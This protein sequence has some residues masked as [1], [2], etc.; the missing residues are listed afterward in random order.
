M[1]PVS[2]KGG[3]KLRPKAKL[4]QGVPAKAIPL[5]VAVIPAILERHSQRQGD[6]GSRTTLSVLRDTVLGMLFT[7]KLAARLQ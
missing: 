5:L 4:T 1:A 2:C 3:T 6:E 7:E